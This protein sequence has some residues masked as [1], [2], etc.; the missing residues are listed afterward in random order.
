MDKIGMDLGKKK[1]DVAVMATVDCVSERFK[2]ATTRE[3]LQRH[4]GNRPAALIAIESCRDSGWVRQE[5]VALGH[6]VVVVDTTRARAIGIGQGRRKT[7]RRDAEALARALWTGTIPEAHVLS[8]R[9][10]A[11]REALHARQTLVRERTKLVTQL[12][13]LWQAQGWPVRSCAAEDFL[14]RLRETQQ[15][16]LETVHVQCLLR[17]LAQLQQ[18]IGTLDQHLAA[19][20]AQEEAYPRLSSVCGVKVIVA[21]SFIAAVDTPQRFAR[22]KQVAAYLGLVPSEWSTGGRQR[23]GRLTRAGNSMARWALVQAAQTLLR[24]RKH[25]Q[26]PLVL[27]AQQVAQR[28]SKR[29]AVAGL[30]RRLAQLLYRLWRDGTYYDP[31]GLGRASAAGLAQ[32]A[33]TTQQHAARLE[34]AA[35]TAEVQQNTAAARS[36]AAAPFGPG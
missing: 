6:E 21:L 24:S 7:D 29:V 17:V 4:F 13:G 30:A 32:Q 15:P 16:L 14:E 34:R 36:Q 3:S 20:A 19:L 2:L 35:V 12:R 23:L 33:R 28:R 8:E 26:D 27:W 10:A 5:L 9:A 11:I 18:E 1:S 31:V 25:A 22:S